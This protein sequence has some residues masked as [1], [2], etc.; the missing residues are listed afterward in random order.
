MFCFC[1]FVWNLRLKLV[2]ICTLWVPWKMNNVSSNQFVNFNYRIDSFFINIEHFFICYRGTLNNVL[3]IY[4]SITT[5]KSHFLLNEKVCAV[6][7][8]PIMNELV[9]HD[10]RN[11]I[12]YIFYLPSSS[13]PLIFIYL[14]YT[15]SI[16]NYL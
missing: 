15:A 2:F 14:T 5:E 3:L 4:I 1:Y 11:Y 10:L 16:N 9:V 7:S 13:L 6:V 12:I 8:A